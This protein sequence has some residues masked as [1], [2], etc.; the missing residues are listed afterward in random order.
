MHSSRL[1]G[2]NHH[3]YHTIPINSIPHW[4]FFP[5]LSPWMKTAMHQWHKRTTNLF[6][7]HKSFF[8]IAKNLTVWTTTLLTKSNYFLLHITKRY[9]KQYKICTSLCVIL[10]FYIYLSMISCGKNEVTQ[11]HH[12]STRNPCHDIIQPK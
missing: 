1:T 8:C 12:L 5:F 4:I 6:T 3:D 10:L 7:L 9:S 11:L 2:H